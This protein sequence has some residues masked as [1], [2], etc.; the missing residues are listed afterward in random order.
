M[1][2]AM[3]LGISDRVNYRGLLADEQMA[4][5]VK[6]QAA[7]LL[8]RLGWHKPHVGSGDRLANRLSVSC[9]VLL[10]LDVGLHVSRRHQSHGMAKRLEFARPMVRRCARPNSDHNRR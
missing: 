10:T 4:C 1:S 3:D 9:I 7:L 2:G 6:H 5:A 8:G